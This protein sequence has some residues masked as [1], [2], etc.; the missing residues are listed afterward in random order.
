MKRNIFYFFMLSVLLVTPIN[1]IAAQTTSD[2]TMGMVQYI[3]VLR[4][5]DQFSEFAQ[6]DAEKIKNIFTALGG[7][8]IMRYINNPSSM[9][10]GLI[11]LLIQQTQS[12][13]NNGDYW[14]VTFT[15]KTS[16]LVYRIYI[17]YQNNNYSYYLVRYTS[18]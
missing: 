1:R 14:S 17:F 10:N 3:G 6:D 2:F 7:G 16:F 13:S 15:K 12:R 9:E 8:T 11:G 5:I 18:Y 4:D